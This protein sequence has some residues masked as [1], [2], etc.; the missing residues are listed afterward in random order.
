MAPELFEVSVPGSLML[1][2]EHAVLHGKQAIVCAVDKRLHMQLIPN[3]TDLIT[4]NDTRLGKFTIAVA[5]I[6]IQPPFKFVLHAIQY[7]QDQLTSGFTLNINSEF[8]SVIGFGSSAAVTVATIAVLAQWLNIPLS[9]DQLFT[10]A[11]KVVLELQGR[12][13]GA[14]IAASIYGGVLAYQIDPGYKMQGHFDRDD[15]RL[16]LPAHSVHQ[17]SHIHDARLDLLA[18]SMHQLSHIHDARLDLPAHSMHQLPH[19]NCE[20]LKPRVIPV[21][22]ALGRS[23]RDPSVSTPQLLAVYCGYKTPTAE[24]IK[25]VQHAQ[26]KD[27]EKFAAIFNIMHD[28]AT[29]SITAIQTADWPLLGK[30]FNQ[31]HALQSALGTSDPTLDQLTQTLITQPHIFGAKI[32]GAGLGDC[33]IG[34]CTQQQPVIFPQLFLQMH[35]NI[36]QQGLTYAI[37]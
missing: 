6:K 34:L 2:G 33:V 24:V 27:P 32:S 13:S 25:I 26:S 18:H 14:D 4:I 36:D 15:A 17:L 7:F 28:C 8:S 20:Q 16:D 31:H 19:I 37:N 10:I 12:G 30:L 5:D 22:P 21:K 35:I 29:A 11:H 1:M 3:N 9:S 23:R